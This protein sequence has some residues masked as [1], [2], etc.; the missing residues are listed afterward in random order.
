MSK[1]VII[2]G[3][4]TTKHE[5]VGGVVA[6]SVDGLTEK[7]LNTLY[8]ALCDVYNKVDCRVLADSQYTRFNGY[9]TCKNSPE[10]IIIEK[11]RINMA[12]ALKR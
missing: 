1:N 3:I 6:F 9:L 10:K 4:K 11:T 12:E 8:I 2:S 7:D 5:H